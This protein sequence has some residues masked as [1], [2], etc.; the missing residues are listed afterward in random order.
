MYQTQNVKLTSDLHPVDRGIK[1]GIRR[2]N[3]W[4]SR[5][6]DGIHIHKY[7]EIFFNLAADATFFVNNE[8]YPTSPGDA[9]VSRPNDLHVCI[10]NTPMYHEYFCLWIDLGDAGELLSFLN[11]E[12]FTPHFTFDKESSARM[13]ELLEGL[14]GLSGREGDALLRTSYLFEVL[15]ILKKSA[16][17]RRENLMP[18]PLTRILTDIDESF[19]EISSV[20]E[21]ASRHFVS[22]STLDRWFREYI[23]TSP[24]KYLESK[25]LAYAARLLETGSGVTEASEAAGFSDCSHFI[26][27][28][29]KK[30]GTTPLKY[31]K[32][33]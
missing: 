24:K 30:F 6:G 2:F 11:T 14:H 26:V 31:K 21:I 22:T 3:I 19:S 32:R 28:F 8:L 16:P 12:E 18:L 27:L 13:K 1:F 33:K 5:I 7:L 10:F 20:A 17:R 29:K 25:K 23:H 4:M 15:A 9:V